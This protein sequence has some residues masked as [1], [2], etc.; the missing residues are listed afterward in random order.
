MKPS[1]VRRLL[2]AEA[3]LF[4]LGLAVWLGLPP[5]DRDLGTFF[6]RTAAGWIV[7]TA[8]MGGA[9]GARRRRENRRPVSA[10]DEL[11]DPP[12]AFG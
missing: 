12:D 1:T 4:V 10:G 3:M 9:A 6:M 11:R 2:A 8:M 5:H 7:L